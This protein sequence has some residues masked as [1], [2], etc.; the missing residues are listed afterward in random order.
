MHRSTR[1]AA[2]L[3]LL[4]ALAAC[5][6][7]AIAPAP[8]P[9]GA[10]A[11]PAAP[12]VAAAACTP[13]ELVPAPKPDDVAY[14]DDR[15]ARA[16][17]ENAA[18]TCATAES[19]LARAEEAILRA[20][21]P[22]PGD[23]GAATPARPWDHRAAPA[24]LDQIARRFALTRAERA[25]LEKNGFVVPARLAF[26]TYAGA[27]HEI[28]QSEL[29]LYVSAD[30]VLHA[31]FRGN[32]AI[33]ARVERRRLAPLLGRTLSA[34]HCALPAAAA[35]YPPETARDLDV[36]LTVARSLLADKAQPAALPGDDA[37]AAA[38][39]EQAK[40]AGAMADVE[41]FGRARKIDFTAF[42]PRGH[43]ATEEGL[44][45]YFRA[46]MWLSR[47]E[48][49]LVSRSSRSSAASEAADPRETPRE[50]I[51]ALALADLVVR[52]GV[53]E[54]VD[55][56]DRA[57]AVFGG[58]REDVSLAQLTA[59]RAGAGI[60]SL[61][62]PAAF[63]RLKAAVG[64]GFQR[65]TRLH[66]MP[67]GTGVLPAIATFLGP[68][69]VADSAATGPLVEPSVGGRHVIGAADMAYV[70]GHDRARAYLKKELDTYPALSTRL[71][72]ARAVAHKPTGGEDLYGLWYRAVLGLADRPAGALPSFMGTEAFADLRMDSAIAAF[73]QLRHNAVL[74]AGQGYDQ[75]GCEIP[76]GFVEPAPAVYD[77]LAAYAD[78]GAAAIGAVDPGDESRARGYFA[79]LGRVLRVLSAIAGDEL[80]GRALSDDE[81]RFLSMVIE[82]TPGSSAGPPTY[83]GWYFDLFPSRVD[84]L[85]RA[86]FIADYFTSGYE[87]VV[88]YAGAGTPRVGLFVVD[89]GGAPRVMVGP[90]ARAYEHHGPLAKRLDD[91]AAAQL[92]SVAEP[93]AASYTVAGPATPAL[94][95]GFS[96]DG[97]NKASAVLE[98][99]RALGPVTIEVLDHHRRPIQ[100]LTRTAGAGKTTFPFRAGTEKRPIEAL[101]VKV[102]EFHAWTQVSWEG[103][104]FDSGVK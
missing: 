96:N 81:R 8:P 13:E 5:T 67:Q 61:G 27:L 62:D 76:D 45:P 9:P 93:W 82:M 56:M 15:H 63:E 1:R 78:R 21:R 55:T 103:G 40:A 47:L 64:D 74:F 29:P 51:D 52:A 94:S 20:P 14:E 75:G 4:A 3:P 30:A 32:D 12:T 83:T 97:P 73:G 44:S 104:Y 41:L 43:Y 28:Y 57:W 48:F 80:A 31:V 84:G 19:N 95:V 72:E 77:A 100:S 79:G 102:G 92:P 58:K 7:D 34:L 25:S 91:E 17:P 50:A 101:H 69:V 60:P 68:R 33:I 36:Y 16:T 42:A 37:P 53:S 24:R 66:Y 23:A 18:D 59:L 88:A 98:A 99:P 39:V 46:A 35:S 85:A 38:L 26:P 11:P 89:T 10:P 70:L 71:D 87:G 86:D 54:A 65:T 49:N 6:T 2:L 22:R 90:V